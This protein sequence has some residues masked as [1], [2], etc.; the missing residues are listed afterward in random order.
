MTKKVEAVSLNNTL[1][2]SV[3]F[4]ADPVEQYAKTQQYLFEVLNNHGVPCAGEI[5]D[6]ISA[7]IQW[8]F[9]ARGR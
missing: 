2:I 3:N 7:M 5:T 4:A 6:A 9:A 1:G 8:A